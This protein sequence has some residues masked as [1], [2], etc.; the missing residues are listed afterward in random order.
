M[1]LCDQYI[2]ESI[3]LDP[4]MNDYLKIEK[5]NHLRDKLP[6]SYTDEYDK[7]EEKLNKKYFNL[8]K[9][10]KKKTFYDELF[11][12]DLKEYFETLYFKD[13]YFPLSYLDNLS[14]SI[15]EDI[16]SKDSDYKF[17]DVNSYKDY[18][19]RLNKLKPMYRT[20][21][22]HMKEGVIKKMTIERIIIQGVIQQLQ[23]LLESNTYKNKFNHYQ[24]IPKNIE[25][26]FLDAIETNVV[27][28]TQ[29]LIQFL[30]EEYVDHCSPTIGLSSIKNG[31]RLYKDIVK[32]YTYKDYTPDY[33]HKLGLKEVQK[34]L[35]YLNQLRTKRKFKGTYQEFIRTMKEN[36]SSQMKDKKSVL[37]DLKSIRER[38][39]KEV[40]E[41]YFDDTIQKKDYYQIKCVTK[42]NKHMSAY[43]LLPD[44]NNERKGTFFINAL[45]TSKVNKH[46]LPVLSLHEGIPGHHYENQLH[47]N[48]NKPLYYRLS[49]YTSYVEGWGFYCESLLEPKNDYE[50]FWQLIYNLHRSIRLV[51][52]TGI[53]SYGWSY[54][55]TFQYM[56]KYLPKKDEELKDEIYR[57]I[58][59]PGQAITYKIGEQFILKLRKEY[60]KKKPND[61]KGFHTLFLKIGPCPLK[62]VEEKF[63]EFQ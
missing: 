21:I 47:M 48:S 20:M 59:D 10:K 27:D 30:I 6:N 44:L 49:D 19:S 12:G 16:N 36:P 40:F 3:L 39:L 58:C 57:Y 60:F 18:I 14:S 34:N 8:L 7:K 25:K 42:E 38:L 23:E 54:E 4:T 13:K 43:Y 45:D 61:Y 53:H 41:K 35:K 26:Q 22:E 51:V 15:M 62:I 33:V 37:S 52:D 24:K 9:K 2:H 28:S 46:E 32:S 11:Y 50:R 1:E 55:K 17:D 29:K 56:K 63:N 31:K 5:Y